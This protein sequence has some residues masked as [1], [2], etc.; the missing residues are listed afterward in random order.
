MNK[1][2]EVSETKTIESI[3]G[4]PA[5]DIDMILREADRELTPE[6]EIEQ[7]LFFKQMKKSQKRA[8]RLQDCGRFAYWFDPHT[9]KRAGYS[10]RCDLFRECPRCLQHRAYTEYERMKNCMLYKE[11]KMIIV[12]SKKDGSA[13][14]RGIHKTK[15]ARY[16]QMD[17]TEIIF[18]EKG[19]FGDDIGEEIPTGWI[20]KQDWAEIVLTP[21]GRNKSGTVH[22]PVVSDDEE[23]YT[24]INAKQFVTDA[25]QELTDQ[26]CDET[27]AET[28]NM[29]PE[30]P[31]EVLLYMNRRLRTTIKKLKERG[32]ECR[33]YQKKLKVIHSRIDWT[34]RMLNF[35]VKSDFSDSVNLTLNTK[36]LTSQR[37]YWDNWDNS[38]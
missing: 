23:P 21:E 38:E 29:Q 34:G 6:E 13:L 25:P 15:Y 8:K 37:S 16:P 10:M 18:F 11:L 28:A 32:Y 27:I 17:G 26:L 30:T 20:A 35:S 4:L 31:E 36:N 19:I 22:I 14:L 12:D 7:E 33:I 2:L 3:F 9:G 5:E 1:V 24:I